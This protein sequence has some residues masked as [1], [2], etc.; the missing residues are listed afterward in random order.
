MAIWLNKKYF[1]VWNDFRDLNPLNESY[2]IEDL[3]QLKSCYGY[4]TRN[5]NEQCEGNSHL[6]ICEGSTLKWER[7]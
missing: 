5:F 7:G 2:E 1:Y 6:R 4:Q 3:K